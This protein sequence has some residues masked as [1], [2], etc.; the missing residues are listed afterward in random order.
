[1]IGKFVVFCSLSFAYCFFKLS[2]RTQTQVHM[3]GRYVI[4]YNFS[5]GKY[6]VIL[7]SMKFLH[8]TVP[9]TLLLEIHH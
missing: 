3:D 4:W 1:M 8:A 5:E 2:F 6:D 7:E 9:K